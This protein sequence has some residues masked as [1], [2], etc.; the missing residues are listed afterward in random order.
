MWYIE[1]NFDDSWKFGARGGICLLAPSNF[2]Q[3]IKN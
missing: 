1:V 2:Q 3:L